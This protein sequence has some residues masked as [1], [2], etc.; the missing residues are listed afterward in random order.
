MQQAPQQTLNGLGLFAD[1]KNGLVDVGGI[2]QFFGERAYVGADTEKMRPHLIMEIA[3]DLTALLFLHPHQLLN[4]T[5]VFRADPGEVDGKPVEL[6]AN[7]DELRRPTGNE[8]DACVAG[9]QTG[10]GIA[11]IREGGERTSDKDHDERQHANAE[12]ERRQNHRTN[13]GP[14]LIDFVS[15]IGGNDDIAE[16]LAMNGGGNNRQARPRFEEMDEPAWGAVRTCIAYHGHGFGFRFGRRHENSH[17]SQIPQIQEQSP[18]GWTR[19]RRFLQTRQCGLDKLA[20]QKFIARAL[21]PHTR[22]GV[23]ANER[24]I[25]E[26]GK[27][28]QRAEQEIQS[29][30]QRKASHHPCPIKA[31]VDFNDVADL[32]PPRDRETTESRIQ[33]Y[34]QKSPGTYP[35]SAPATTRI[36]PDKRQ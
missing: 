6:L 36:A 16:A 17:V 30:A 7:I 13:F 28:E 31:G 34:I 11:H 18:Q 8:F 21:R 15:R 10:D 23:P 5:R 12:Y 4:E 25:G 9:R 3:G 14:D 32:L 29:R 27:K 1:G 2:R 22:R 35:R 24:D 20:R 19:V 26:K 33:E